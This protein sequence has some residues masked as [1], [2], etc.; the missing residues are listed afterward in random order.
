MLDTRQAAAHLGLGYQHFRRLLAHDQDLP[1]H[2]EGRWLRFDSAEL[3][4][5]LAAQ[6]APTHCRPSAHP[7][8]PPKRGLDHLHRL[9]SLGWADNDIAA[10]LGARAER[11]NTWWQD[12]VPNRWTGHLRR[13]VEQL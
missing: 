10:A 2:R 12:G 13:L 6:R 3:D 8:T 9:R 1:R 11:V 7:P 5:W 4:R